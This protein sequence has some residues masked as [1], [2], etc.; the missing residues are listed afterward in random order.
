[1][2]RYARSGWPEQGIEDPVVAMIYGG[3]ENNLAGRD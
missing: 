2:A 3:Q 1:M